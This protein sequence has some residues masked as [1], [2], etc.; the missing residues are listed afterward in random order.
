MKNVI[1]TR[2]IVF[3]AAHRMARADLTDA[4]NKKLYGKCSG[5]NYHGHNY[6]LEVSVKG[7]INP[8]NDMVM[9][10]TELKKI[11]ERRVMDTLDHKNLNLDVPFLRG[12][13]PTAERIAEA[14]WKELIKDIPKKLLYKVKL[15]ETENNTVTIKAQ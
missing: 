3:S 5:P 13:N 6:V 11:L 4:Q 15:R 10:L 14:I 7:L 9:N 1:L 8:K 2:R 12:V